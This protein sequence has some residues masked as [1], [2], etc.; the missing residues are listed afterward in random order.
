MN[1]LRKELQREVKQQL[2]QKRLSLF[3]QRQKG[4]RKHDRQTAISLY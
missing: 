2:E 3:E 1:Q 4:Y